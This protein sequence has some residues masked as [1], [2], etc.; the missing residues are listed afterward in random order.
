M[1]LFQEALCPS[2]SMVTRLKNAILQVWAYQG[3]TAV[4]VLSDVC[5]SVIVRIVIIVSIVI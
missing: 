3:R 2:H 4:T 5:I 1:E